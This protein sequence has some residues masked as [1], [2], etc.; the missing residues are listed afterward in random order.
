MLQNSLILYVIIA[1]LAMGGVVHGEGF[2]SNENMRRAV[3]YNSYYNYNNFAEP[4]VNRSDTRPWPRRTNNRGNNSGAGSGGVP[5]PSPPIPTAAPP[6]TSPPAVS[7]APS[8]EITS[9]PAPGAEVTPA[10]LPSPVPS[11]MPSPAPNPIPGPIPSP[12]S[13]PAPSPIPS[14]MPSTV[15]SPIPSPVP[16]PAPTPKPFD[17]DRDGYYTITFD[18]YFKC[19]N[20]VRFTPP[21]GDFLTFLDLGDSFSIQNA[22]ADQIWLRGLHS[23]EY[24]LPS[25]LNSA[26]RINVKGNIEV[27]LPLNRTE[28]AFTMAG[29]SGLDII[30]QKQNRHIIALSFEG[31]ARIRLDADLLLLVSPGVADFTLNS[32][33]AVVSGM[34]AQIPNFL[35]GMMTIH[36]YRLDTLTEFSIHPDSI[37]LQ[38]GYARAI[39]LISRTLAIENGH[40]DFD[41][42]RGTI[43][44]HTV[45]DR[46][47]SQHYY[48]HW[49]QIRPPNFFDPG[50]GW[51]VR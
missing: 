25:G 22:G 14:P 24:N 1:A 36:Q 11:P 3:S 30:T 44:G 38:G 4:T 5:S 29:G 19:S 42:L 10:P 47:E 39:G 21:S 18:G 43:G 46:R 8:P 40:L 35:V 51:V 49:E 26:I 48:W 41:G 15:P 16:S 9:S 20:G 28:W 6:T 45:I 13:S 12:A 17:L 50:Q 37:I 32:R 23:R 7:P 2:L 33:G 27:S 31:A 34:D